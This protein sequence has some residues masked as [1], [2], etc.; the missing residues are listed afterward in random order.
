MSVIV[1][2][3]GLIKKGT[4]KH[5]IMIPDSPSRYKKHKISLCRTANLSRSILLIGIKNIV[6]KRE[7]NHNNIRYI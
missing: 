3:L 4:D 6:Q 7:Q 5:L 2:V 1:G